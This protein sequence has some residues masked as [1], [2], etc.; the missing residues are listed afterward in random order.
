MGP[1]ARKRWAKSRDLDEPYMEKTM[2][3]RIWSDAVKESGIPFKPTAYQVRH[4][5]AS[6]LIDAGE[7]PKAV[8]YRLG[9]ADLR[10]TAR[11][12]HVMDEFG[13]SAA[14]RFGGLLPPLLLAGVTGSGKTGLNALA[15][16][17]STPIA[18]PVDQG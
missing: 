14:K 11:Y 8:M 6:W 1:A 2:W 3:N 4:T 17:I 7:S 15:A 13:D 9:Q 16:V 18:A 12:V 5:H 10:T